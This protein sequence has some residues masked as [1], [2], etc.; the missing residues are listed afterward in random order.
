M[1]DWIDSTLWDKF[2]YKFLI[3][4][5]KSKMTFEVV[6]ENA[7]SPAEGK[8]IIFAANHSNSFDLPDAVKATGRHIIPLVGK[9]RLGLDDRFFFRL[10]GVIYVDRFDKRSGAAVKQKIL[11]QLKTRTPVCWY[12]EG[13]WN[14]TDNLLMLNMKWGIIDVASA[15][16]AQIIPLALD[17]D[18]DT[19]VC[20]A[21]FGEPILGRALADKAEGIRTLRDAMASLRY[22]LMEKYHRIDRADADLAK[23]K[24]EIMTAIPEYP[25]LEP[26]KEEKVVFRPYE[27]VATLPDKIRPTKQN[28][29]L[30]NKR[31]FG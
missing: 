6:T 24:N 1:N 29:F 25:P 5:A 21:L 30:F 9:Q 23:L 27:T 11:R 26:E 7:Y 31:F 22:E 20:H 17:Y 16:N 28:A 14:L 4:L 15:A 19:M 18:R 2:A 3:S 10:N 8:P 12:P 13:T